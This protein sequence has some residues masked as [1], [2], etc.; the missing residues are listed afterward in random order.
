MV[1]ELTEC[2]TQDAHS[3]FSALRTSFACDRAPDDV[4]QNVAGVGPTVWTATFDVTDLRGTAEPRRLTEPVTVS[5]QGGYW[6]VARLRDSLAPAFA[7]RVM[8][9]AAGDQEQEVQLR[10]EN[11]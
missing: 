8:G 3:V 2:A 4:P 5:L 1:V 7:V 10:L 11:R 6:A 9:T